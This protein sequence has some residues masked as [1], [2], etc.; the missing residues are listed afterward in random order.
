MSKLDATDI[1]G[2]ALR[3][4]ALPFARYMFLEIL[5][6]DRGK[7]FIE[8]LLGQIT[9]G[10]HWDAGKPEWTLNI[11]FTHK[12]LVNLNLPDP[13]LLSFPVEF[14]QGMK[15]R[16]EILADTGK[17]DPE[18]WDEVWRAG[19]VDIWL[20]VNS[21]TKETLDA[22]CADMEKLM[23]ETGGARKRAAQDACVRAA[24]GTGRRGRT[25]RRPHQHLPAFRPG[26]R[27]H[28]CQFAR[29]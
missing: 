28:A 7:Q 5:D 13:S 1:Q 25:F 22:R 20:A 12:G 15:A 29:S 3:G 11:A 27:V 10:E 16:K 14:V 8:Q 26:R 21:K 23:S 4:Y 6:P 17:N 9:T 19:K 24:A 2:F 18:H